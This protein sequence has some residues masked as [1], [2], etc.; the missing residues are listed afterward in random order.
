VYVV[1][2]DQMT[3]FPDRLK[4]NESIANLVP[5]IIHTLHVGN[6]GN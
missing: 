3:G 4:G 5:R 2:S 1:I 6:L